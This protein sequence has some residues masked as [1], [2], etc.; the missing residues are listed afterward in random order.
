MKFHSRSLLCLRT[1]ATIMHR[2]YIDAYTLLHSAALCSFLLDFTLVLSNMHNPRYLSPL[3]REGSADAVV[4]FEVWENQRWV[5]S[6]GFQPTL[7]LGA[8][9]SSMQAD[10][11]PWSTVF[12]FDEQELKSHSWLGNVLLRNYGKECVCNP[13]RIVV[14]FVPSLCFTPLLHSVPPCLV[15]ALSY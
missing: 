11:P 6:Q 4:S 14:C 7:W 3:A 9:S 12:R 15:D 5:P 1:H 8:A 2:S 10:P 13:S